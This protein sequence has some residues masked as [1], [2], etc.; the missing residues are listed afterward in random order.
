MTITLTPAP[1]GEDKVGK[2]IL[3]VPPWS[4]SDGDFASVS[5]R[6]PDGETMELLEVRAVTTAGSVPTGLAAVVTDETNSVTVTSQ[7]TSKA[8]GDP[9]D[10]VDGPAT[11]SFKA[12]N[13]TGN[14]QD[15]EGDF[16]IQFQ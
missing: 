7:E 9:I 14:S 16:V 13:Q 10:T 1:A 8:T 11:V 2:S 3:S 15:V 6:V 5:Y 12:D 4:V